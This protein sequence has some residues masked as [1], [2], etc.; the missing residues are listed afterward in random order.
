MTASVPNAEQRLAA[1]FGETIARLHRSANGA[2]EDCALVRR[3]AERAWAEA[4]DGQVCVDLGPD[5]AGLSASLAASP[6][7]TTDPDERVAPLVLDAGALYLHRL[8][9]AETGLARSLAMLDRPAPIADD[10]AIDTRL[11][12]L[13]PEVGAD[14]PQRRAVWT[15]LARR[16]AVV[17]GG[18]GTGKTTTMARL[19]VAFLNL[20]PDARVAFAAPT[21]KAAARLAQSLAAQLPGL[22]PS[23]ALAARL[24]AS[25]RT[26]H[27]LLG[28]G[29][30][31]PGRAPQPRPLAF[32]LVIVDEAS[33]IDLE[34]AALLAGAIPPGGRLVLAGDMDQLAS[35]DAGAVFADVCAN[36]R[37]G[38]VRLDRN[39]RQKDA[40][41]ILALAAALR[42]GNPAAVAKALSGDA[43]EITITPAADAQRVAAEAIE[44]YDAALRAV[45]EGRSPQEVL[46]AYEAY[47]VLTALRE[48]PLGARSVNAAIAARVRRI[49]GASAAPDWYPGRLVMVRRN[50]PGLGLFNGDVGVCLPGPDGRLAIAFAVGAGIRW[51]PLLQMPACDDAFAI[52]VHKSQGS[53]FETVALLPGP[54]GHRLNS[55]ELVYT[56]V[57][58]ARRR[59]RLWASVKVLQAAANNRTRR[60]GRLA[61]RLAAARER[62]PDA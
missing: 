14:D 44:G 49:V 32:D 4:A 45:R 40:P 33:M 7:V 39:Y 18:P 43:A 61:S 15:A 10:A 58:R 16:L 35:V 42:D 51:L 60:H 27:R 38:I 1:A 48:G 25:G 19:L 34:L 55:R 28:L 6:A 36:D 62:A 50:E 3:W 59:L 21:G 17:S 29:V 57:T 20:N 30:S 47:R 46:S 5:A 2:D 23:G 53:E 31:T 11:A 8:W 26:V 12:P 22:D 56:G 37:E 52:T 13:F 9:Q 24:P 54:E 41:G